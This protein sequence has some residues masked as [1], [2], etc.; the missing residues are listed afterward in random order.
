MGSAFSWT[1][2]EAI[3]VQTAKEAGV[4]HPKARWEALNLS[5]L[6]QTGLVLETGRTPTVVNQVTAALQEGGL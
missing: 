2:N 5:S 6:R 1:E 4:K 3:P